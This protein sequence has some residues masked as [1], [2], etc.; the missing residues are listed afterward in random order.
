MKQVTPTKR[1]LNTDI[2]GNNATQE[3]FE[4]TYS[5]TLTVTYTVT[6]DHGAEG[7]ND[8][9]EG[10]SY[11]GWLNKQLGEGVHVSLDGCRGITVK[12]S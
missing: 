4:H 9:A 11:V 8:H 2:M 7:R 3:I 1:N 12:K 10:T 6:S 5:V